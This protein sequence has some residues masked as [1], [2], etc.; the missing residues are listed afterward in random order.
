MASVKVQNDEFDMNEYGKINNAFS[1]KLLP[2]EE[3][4]KTN[5][6][7]LDFRS[8]IYSQVNFRICYKIIKTDKGNIL[9]FS[10]DM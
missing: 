7:K 10:Y 8:Y 3:V 5:V 9:S 6:T 4:T 1:V 2:V